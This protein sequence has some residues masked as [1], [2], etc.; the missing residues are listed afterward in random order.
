[1]CGFKSFSVAAWLAVGGVTGI[2]L[3]PWQLGDLIK[4]L[5][6]TTDQIETSCPTCR[7]SLHEVDAKFCRNCG[8]ELLVRQVIRQD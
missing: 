3:I 5:V 6:K 2:A 1:M 7:L 8:S 4:R